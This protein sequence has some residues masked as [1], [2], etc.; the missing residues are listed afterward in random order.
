MKIH[1]LICIDNTACYFNYRSL[2]WLWHRFR[3]NLYPKNF[4]LVQF[5]NS[6]PTSGELFT[7]LFVYVAINLNIFSVLLIV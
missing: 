5:L 7:R 4:F 1:T 6:T 2:T 3:Y